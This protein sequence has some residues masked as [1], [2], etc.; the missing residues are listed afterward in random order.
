MYRSFW[1]RIQA[2]TQ[3]RVSAIVNPESTTTPVL[4]LKLA[5]HA[6]NKS[7][8]DQ[9]PKNNS[10]KVMFKYMRSRP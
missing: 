2:K 8:M 4:T 9:I 10:E 1:D 5:R 7:L 3:K 6:S